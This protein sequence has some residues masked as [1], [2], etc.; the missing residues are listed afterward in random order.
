MAVKQNNAEK[1][2]TA[3]FAKER[4]DPPFYRIPS[5]VVTQKGVLLAFCEARH[6]AS[7]DHAEND[8][9][10]RRSFDGGHTWGPVQVVAED[11]RNSLNN[12][13]AVVVRETGRII[14]MYQRWPC[15]YHAGDD[16]AHNIK[17]VEP[18]YEGDRICRTFL[19]TSDDDGS[20]WS[21]PR[22]ITRA[23][24][25]T[26]EER[27]T[28]AGPGI[29]IQLRRGKHKGRIIMPFYE[30]PAPYRI[31]A[32]YSDDLGENWSCGAPA[33]D[34]D[35]GNGNENQ[36]VELA[37]GSVM[38]NS[39]HY[40]AGSRACRKVALSRDGG[41]TWS[42]LKDEP[43]LVEPGCQGSILRYSD[44]LDGLRSRILFSNP[45]SEKRRENGTVRLSY[46]E[47]QTWPVS[48]VIKSE[49]MFCYSCLAVLPDFS[50]GCLYERVRDEKSPITIT[51]ANFTLAWLTD[52][53]DS[54]PGK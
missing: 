20:S 18:G 47:A 37:D 50:I 27:A 34:A 39:R 7:G 2:E 13:T 11:G 25:R 28:V 46:D 1:W 45:A 4:F 42:A 31:Y 35:A 14:L 53:K 41:E 24:K 17:A 52:G 22:E 51:Y 36:V 29:G 54:E 16:P 33:E 48:R 49:G 30:G 40:G 9:L 15:G 26:G 12:P 6:N 23:V 5:L 44:P 3:V 19:I 38:V 32:V 8:I 43:I 21:G 10:L